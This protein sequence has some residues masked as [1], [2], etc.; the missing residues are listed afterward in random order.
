MMIGLPVFPDPADVNQNRRSRADPVEL[1]SYLS[2]SWFVQQ[3][4]SDV[5]QNKPFVAISVR[6]GRETK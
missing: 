5:P 3:L 2:D 4:E 1:K 6:K